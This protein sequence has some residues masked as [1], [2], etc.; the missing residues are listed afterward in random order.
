MVRKLFSDRHLNQ[1]LKGSKKL[2][3]GRHRKKFG[4]QV[5]SKNQSLKAEIDG[6]IVDP[7]KDQH[8]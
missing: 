7:L 4:S 1:D 3:F 8:I 6:G 2:L 5:D